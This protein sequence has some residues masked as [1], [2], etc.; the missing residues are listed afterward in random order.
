MLH[1][2][3]LLHSLTNGNASRV[4]QYAA[5]YM[6]V[7]AVSA[8]AL[9]HIVYKTYLKSNC[10]RNCH[11]GCVEYVC[12]VSIVPLYIMPCVSVTR[13]VGPYLHPT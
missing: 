11:I 1:R 12:Y 6:S 13:S 9:F 4:L 3:I 7:Y 5:C 8:F 2:M 10:C